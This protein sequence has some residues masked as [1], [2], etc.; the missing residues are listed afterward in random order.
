[1]DEVQIV[2]EKDR[3]RDRPEAQVPGALVH[4]A[5]A[6]GVIGILQGAPI[7]SE[8]PVADKPARPVKTESAPQEEL[9][10]EREQCLWP[11]AADRLRRNVA[12]EF[13]KA[14]PLPRAVQERLAADHERAGE[15]DE[16]RDRND[17]PVEAGEQAI[18]PIGLQPAR[19]VRQV[20]VVELEIGAIAAM[21]PE[22]ADAL[23]RE[24]GRKERRKQD[25]GELVDAAIG[26]EGAVHAF[27]LQ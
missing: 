19:L 21:M 4:V 12:H 10:N 24:R 13:P 11:D 16:A 9:E 8:R 20:V 6:P 25:A 27:M 15:I 22:M 17:R 1:M 18:D 23:D 26:M 7:E 5:R 2:V 14:P 3:L